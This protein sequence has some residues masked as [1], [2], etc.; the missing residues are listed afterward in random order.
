MNH[1][2]IKKLQ[3]RKPLIR[4]ILTATLVKMLFDVPGL[5]LG[6]PKSLDKKKDSKKSKNDEILSGKDKIDARKYGY[7][8]K[9][10][11]KNF[12]KS[13]QPS[14]SLKVAKP[15][16]KPTQGQNGHPNIC[17]GRNSGK[18]KLQIKMEQKLCGAR[19]RFLNQKL[20]QSHSQDALNHFKE[21]PEDFEKVFYFFT[22]LN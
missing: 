13:D 22:G 9:D 18:T 11:F 8:K 1:A 12:E 2:E 6:E 21:N 14:V 19:F 7:M 16:S 20:Y 4:S 10:S 3:I 5:N 15:Y 17:M